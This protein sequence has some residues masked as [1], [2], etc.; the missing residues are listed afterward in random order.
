MDKS[1]LEKFQ[2]LLPGLRKGFLQWTVNFT[3]IM[4]GFLYIAFV[5]LWS[6]SASI[7]RRI[8]LPG[9]Y[10]FLTISMFFI[11]AS[12]MLL[13]I[14]ADPAILMIQSVYW[15]FIRAPARFVFM[16]GVTLYPLY[17]LLSWAV[18]LGIVAGFLLHTLFSALDSCFTPSVDEKSNIQE[19]PVASPIFSTLLNVHSH[20]ESPRELAD[21]TKSKSAATKSHK[22]S[23]SVSLNE[24]DGN[25]DKNSSQSVEK[26]KKEDPKF[27][28]VE[29][30]IVAEFP[31]P[32]PARKRKH[33]SPKSV[34]SKSIN[35]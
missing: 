20:P 17:V 8:L 3:N 12:T 22:K 9:I 30:R 33:R 11:K 21:D 27:S 32:S 6:I 29:T 26:H 34:R 28:P 14:I 16:V 5:V 15:Y 35:A 31:I 18:F 23:S 13:L 10:L 19:L 2:G 25:K 1:I 24:K 7:F 4:S